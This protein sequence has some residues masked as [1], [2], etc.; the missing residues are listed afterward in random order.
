MLYPLLHRLER[1]GHVK[2]DWRTPPEGR[3]RRYDMITK[4]G[5]AALADQQRQWETVTRALNDVWR[6]G[7]R[8]WG[9]WRAGV[10]DHRVA[11][12]RRGAPGGTAATSTSSRITFAARSRS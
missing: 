6:L 9:E 8:L 12:V 1:L 4:D 2:T 5:R 7:G 3:R 10:A 11:R